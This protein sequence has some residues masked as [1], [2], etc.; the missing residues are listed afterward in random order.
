MKVSRNTIILSIAALI[1]AGALIFYALQSGGHGNTGNIADT[2]NGNSVPAEYIQPPLPPPP[3]P[4]IPSEWA[5]YP[6]DANN[7][8]VAVSPLG[9]AWL[10][11]V[12]YSSTAGL[13]LIVPDKDMTPTWHLQSDL[14]WFCPERFAGPFLYGTDRTTDT[15]YLYIATIQDGRVQPVKSAVPSNGHVS[16]DRGYYAFI[17]GKLVTSEYHGIASS[18]PRALKVLDLTT[19]E[20]TTLVTDNTSTY[21]RLLGWS[22]DQSTIGYEVTNYTDGLN[23]TQHTEKIDASDLKKNIPVTDTGY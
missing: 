17:T 20:I 15:P 13:L 23:F 12:P 4:S 6:F 16:P 1:L 21:L 2:A 9:T 14:G 5:G 18:S 3:P 22:K 10:S 11:W 19:G 8:C 7:N